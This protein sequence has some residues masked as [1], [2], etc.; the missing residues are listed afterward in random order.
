MIRDVLDVNEE[1]ENRTEYKSL[2][3]IKEQLRERGPIF[4]WFN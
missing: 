4:V 3:D 1:L 2:D